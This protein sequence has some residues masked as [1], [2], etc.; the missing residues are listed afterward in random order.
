LR[1]CDSSVDFPHPA[2]ART[3]A[4]LASGASGS[5]ATSASRPIRSRGSGA[6][7]FIARSGACACADMSEV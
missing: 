4:S 2:G 6:W 7:S 3:S 1:H 5:R